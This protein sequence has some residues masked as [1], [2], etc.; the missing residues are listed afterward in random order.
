LFNEL[1][2]IP[3]SDVNLSV[4][5]FPTFPYISNEK[6]K[7]ERENKKKS[8]RGNT[9]VKSTE[10]I[11][12]AEKGKD[13]DVNLA[14][15]APVHSDFFWSSGKISCWFVRKLRC[16]QVT[17]S[18]LLIVHNLVL[19]EAVGHNDGVWP[20]VLL[21]YVARRFLCL[22]RHPMGKNDSL[23]SLAGTLRKSSPVPN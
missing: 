18:L 4:S 5:A 16:S 2:G 19:G 9:P 22:R 1:A 12:Q 17:R 13:E 8:E 21:V 11:Q 14:I 3:T 6:E 10:K 7:K 20:E 23:L 15:N